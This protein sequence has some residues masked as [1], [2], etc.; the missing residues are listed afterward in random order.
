MF[1]IDENQSVEQVKGGLKEK[2]FDMSSP[3]YTVHMRRVQN[4][5][6]KTSDNEGRVQDFLDGV[7]DGGT[8]KGY[9]TTKM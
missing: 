3:K 9:L 5:T 7:E 8:G 6:D 2:L 4:L 1:V